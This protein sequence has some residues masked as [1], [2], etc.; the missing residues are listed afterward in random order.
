MSFPLNDLKQLLALNKGMIAGIAIWSG[1]LAG[2]SA[3]KFTTTSRNCTALTATLWAGIGLGMLCSLIDLVYEALQDTCFASRRC[4]QGEMLFCCCRFPSLCRQQSARALCCHDY[5]SRHSVVDISEDGVVA[6]QTGDCCNADAGHLKLCHMS[7]AVTKAVR[8]ALDVPDD[9][10]SYSPRSPDPVRIVY[11]AWAPCL[12]TRVDRPRLCRHEAVLALYAESVVR[13]AANVALW[14]AYVG[15]TASRWFVQS[16]CA[17][18]VVTGIGFIR[19]VV[20]VAA[21]LNT[22]RLLVFFSYKGRPHDA[23]PSRAGVANKV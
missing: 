16:S 7:S 15:V 8:Q 20:P 3:L 17:G 5:P 9:T 18:T 12:Y 11:C 21:L 1:A 19:V 10:A 6:T 22:L 23:K 4:R 13:L 14:L 2:V